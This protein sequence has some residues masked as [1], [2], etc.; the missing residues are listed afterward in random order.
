[1]TAAEETWTGP[2]AMVGGR[3]VSEGVCEREGLLDS[4]PSFRETGPAGRTEVQRI[5]RLLS[6]WPDTVT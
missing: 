4:A 3:G 2:G 5:P 6:A 1:M